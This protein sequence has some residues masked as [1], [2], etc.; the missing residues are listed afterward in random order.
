MSG[1]EKPS[2]IAPRVSSF[3]D[4]TVNNCSVSS[5]TF[6]NDRMDG[7]RALCA[8]L[9]STIGYSLRE[10]HYSPHGQQLAHSE[11]GGGNTRDGECLVSNCSFC[12]LPS[13][14]G[15]LVTRPA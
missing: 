3:L 5:S 7:R 1:G 14:R 8:E 15:M 12:N 2:G 6:L 4:K 9:P 11:T 10:E 13:K